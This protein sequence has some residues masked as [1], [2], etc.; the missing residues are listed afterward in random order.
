MAE[1]GFPG[2]IIYW[3]PFEVHA[4]ERLLADHPCDAVL[5][6]G[7]GHSVYAD[8]AQFA[9]VQAALAACPN[10]VLL[11]PSPDLDESVRISKERQGHQTWYENDFDE[12]FVK[13]PSN[14]TLAKHVVYTQGKTPDQTRDDILRRL[15]L[16]R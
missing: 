5:D 16:M 10:V 7:A 8:P 15:G 9:R 4:V 12:L 1:D 2:V 11:L 6:F 3:K 14:Q 13:H